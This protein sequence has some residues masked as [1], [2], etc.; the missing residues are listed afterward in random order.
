M[1]SSVPVAAFR[2]TIWSF[3]RKNGRHDLPWRKT[4]DPYKILVSEMMLQQTQVER[5]IPFYTKFLKQ[6]PTAKALA[7]AP[8]SD[9]LAAWQGLGYNRRAKLLREAARE[10]ADKPRFGTRSDFVQELEKLPG[11]GP[12][13]ARA[14]AAFAFNADTVFIETNIRTVVIHR[15]FPERAAVSDTEIEIIV[16]AALP[17]G[18]AREWYSALMDYGSYL[19]RSGVK[20]NARSTAYAKQA[21]F[22]GSVRQVR[23][24]I[25]AAVTNGKPLTHIHRQYPDRFDSAL[26]GLERD[27]M[28]RKK[29]RAWRVA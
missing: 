21:R 2:R 7:E 29:G 15:F 23:G 26:A 12:Y 8:L 14:V 17:K 20:L 24:A 19:K 3:Y 1:S 16:R 4:V 13:T 5:V 9:V 18:R 28:I 25:L 10:L 11:V 6:F 27:G 22:E